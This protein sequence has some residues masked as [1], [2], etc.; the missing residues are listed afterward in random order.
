MTEYAQAFTRT[1]PRTISLGEQSVTFRLMAPS[2][3][4][5]ILAF[6]RTLPPD[7]LLFLRL[8]I[9]T[10]EA[11]DEWVGNIEAGR[12]ITVVAEADGAIAGYASVHH[13]QVLWN[14]HVGELRVI[15]GSDY[16]RL[17]L[18]RRL[19]DEVFA[20]AREI[21]LRKI[22]AQMTPDQKGARAT[23]E[24]LGFRPEALLADYVVDREG[25]TRDLLIMSNDVAGFTDVEH[26]GAKA[27]APST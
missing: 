14:R 24:R 9:T 22:T 13:N 5:A 6:A 15:V 4:N 16:R 19:T 1:Y 21:G 26:V 27:S 3:R 23:F 8:D 11:V 2:D 25:K 18:G 7:D 12:T 10:P 20:I 17:G